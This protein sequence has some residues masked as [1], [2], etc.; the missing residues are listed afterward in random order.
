MRRISKFLAVAA[1]SLLIGGVA[2][3]QVSIGIA[4]GIQIP[5]G[6]FGKGS[7]LGFGGGVSGEYAITEN[8]GVGLNVGFFTFGA[9]D[10][11]EGAS[12]STSIIP[13]ALTGKYYFITEGFKPYGGVN[14]GF[15]MV[16]FHAKFE[17]VSISTTKGYMG[18]APVLGCQY[19]FS[20]ALALDVNAKYNLIFGKKEELGTVGTIGFNV[21]IVYSFGG[22]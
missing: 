11:E 9:K 8:I 17:G 16:G 6:D 10:L 2:N 15:N 5:M 1:L 12:G 22:K 3:A 7:N 4:P 13:I 20:D 21:G 18:V 19:A 14:V